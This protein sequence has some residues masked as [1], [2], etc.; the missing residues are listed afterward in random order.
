MSKALLSRPARS[1]V[2]R[3]LLG[4]ACL[5]VAG[6][7]GA[8]GKVVPERTAAGEVTVESQ[9]L[10]PRC[11][12]QMLDIHESDLAASL[13]HEIRTRLHAGE[14]QSMIED[15]RVSRYGQRI[16][17]VKRGMIPEELRFLEARDEV[18]IQHHA[19]ARTNESAATN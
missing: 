8:A 14:S 12:H 7:A 4:L 9:L 6:A 16:R 5:F 11:W 10:A 3:S 19:S 2:A 1:V 13:R 15:E 18:P 17:A